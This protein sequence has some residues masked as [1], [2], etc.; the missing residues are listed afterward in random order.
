MQ[1][2]RCLYVSLQKDA[3]IIFSLEMQSLNL[4]H[5]ILS[6][7]EHNDCVLHVWTDVGLCGRLCCLQFHRFRLHLPLR[8]W[9]QLHP[10]VLVPQSKPKKNQNKKKHVCSCHQSHQAEPLPHCVA[11][12]QFPLI[13]PLLQASFDPPAM[14]CACECSQIDEETSFDTVKSYICVLLPLLF[15]E[16]VFFM[17]PNVL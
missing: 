17:L 2:N 15:S 13:R 3:F 14:L 4:V 11:T 9:L 10:G 16:S 8:D 6:Y 12:P 1:M 5:V 7:R